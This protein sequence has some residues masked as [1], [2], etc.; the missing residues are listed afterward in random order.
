MKMTGLGVGVGGVLMVVGCV[1]DG[2]AGLGFYWW[3]SQLV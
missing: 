3:V 1:Q 2:G